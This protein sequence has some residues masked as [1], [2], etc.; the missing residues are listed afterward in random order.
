MRLLARELLARAVGVT[1]GLSV[2]EARAAVE[3][4]EQVA[5]GAAH[6]GGVVRRVKGRAAP[7]VQ[8]EAVRAEVEIVE[9]EIVTDEPSRDA[10]PARVEV[11]ER[12]GSR[13][14]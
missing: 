7:R 8:V 9:A 6:V 13:W 11:V 10:L 3:L 14:R 12:S 5:D 1:T 4:G 2:E